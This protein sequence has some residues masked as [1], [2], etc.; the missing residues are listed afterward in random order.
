ML[1]QLYIPYFSCTTSHTTIFLT[2]KRNKNGKGKEIFLSLFFF[3]FIISTTMLQNSCTEAQNSR[4]DYFDAHNTAVTMLRNSVR[5]GC[6]RGRCSNEWW[7]KFFYYDP[8]GNFVG[9]GP[10]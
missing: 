8:P 2:P 6:A 4:Q 1:H 10:Y 7:V 9:Q 3:N 5:L